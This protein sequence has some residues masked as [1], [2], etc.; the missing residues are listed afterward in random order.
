MQAQGDVSFQPHIFLYPL[1]HIN[2]ETYLKRTL[3]VRKNPFNCSSV[4][5]GRGAGES[6]EGVG[7]S[8]CLWGL[9]N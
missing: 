4:H 8:L 5:V 9:K 3:M 1:E 6:D 2:T 7:I